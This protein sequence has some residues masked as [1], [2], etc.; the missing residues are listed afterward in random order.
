MSVTELAGNICEGMK[1]VDPAEY[2]SPVTFDDL[3]VVFADWEMGSEQSE[4]PAAGQEAA[5]AKCREIYDINVG[6]DDPPVK[7]CCQ[8]MEMEISG[9]K[10]ASGFPVNSDSI[11][12]AEGV[13]ENWKVDAALF[14]N[15]K[16]IAGSIAAVVSAAAIQQI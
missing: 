16:L 6:A 7:Y 2:Y 5:I 3:T 10:A 14:N 15:A 11:K 13:D 1:V 8:M 4:E 9:V 12:A